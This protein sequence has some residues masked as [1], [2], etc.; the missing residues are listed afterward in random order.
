MAEFWI[1]LEPDLDAL[2]VAWEELQIAIR[3]G[4]SDV[5]AKAKMQKSIAKAT[6]IIFTRITGETIS[7]EEAEA[8]LEEPKSLKKTSTE[9][10]GS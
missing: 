8:F 10:P 6:A 4:E 7:P 3:K 1:L 5:D 2:L 9:E